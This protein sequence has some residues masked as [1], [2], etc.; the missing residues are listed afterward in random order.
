MPFTISHAAVVLPFSRLLARWQLLSAA[1][2]GAM[3]P[4]FRL[5]LPW[6]MRRVRDAQRHGVVDILPAGGPGHLLGYS[7]GWSRRR[8]WRFCPRAPYARWRLFAAPAD[9]RQRASM[10]TGG[11]RGAGGSRDAPGVG[12]IHSRGCARR[13]HDSRCSMSPWLEIG[14]HHLM[15]VRLMQ[16]VSSLIGLVVG[17][18]HWSLMACAAGASR[19]CRTGLCARTERR[20]WVLAYV[21]AAVALSCAFYAWVRSGTATAALEVRA[22]F[23]HGSR[24]P[25]RPRG[26][27]F[28]RQCCAWICGCAL[29]VTV[30]PARIVEH[31]L[32]WRTRPRICSRFPCSKPVRRRGRSRCGLAKRRWFGRRTCNRAFAR[33]LMGGRRL[34]VSRFERTRRF[35]GANR[36]E[37]GRRFE[38]GRCRGR[39]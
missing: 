23:Y 20:Q 12:C 34:R 19:Q 35:G 9:I 4:D 32:E 21:L 36:F 18:W 24:R 13:A 37:R 7:K 38:G 15:G 26:R 16:D 11:L 8:C 1:V 39:R 25:A 28:G 30:R 27:A 10:G 2:I 6:R 29:C 5:F 14:S 31:R 22:D 33:R 17:V 3:V